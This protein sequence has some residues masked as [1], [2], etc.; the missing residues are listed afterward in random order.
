MRNIG[1]TGIA[2]PNGNVLAAISPIGPSERMEQH[3]ERWLA[4]LLQMP[5][6]MS[7]L[8]GFL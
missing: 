2:S 4:L 7:R 6:E 3:V 5:Q 8:N 1:V